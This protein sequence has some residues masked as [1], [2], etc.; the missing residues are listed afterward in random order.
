MAK[1]RIRAAIK[2]KIKARAQARSQKPPSRLGARRIKS[3]TV[4]ATSKVIGKIGTVKTAIENLDA[5]RKLQHFRVDEFAPKTRLNFTKGHFTVKTVENGEELEEALRLRFHVFHK[6]YMAKR[7]GT[8]VDVDALDL[9]CDH[10]LIRDNRTGKAV[11]TYRFNS[12]TFSDTF[13]SSSEFDIDDVLQLPGNKLELGRAAIH[14]DYRTGAVIAMIWRG[15]SEYMDL[16]DTDVMFGC[17]SIKTTDPL[18]IGLVTQYFQKKGLLSDALK[19]EP[20]KKYRVKSLRKALDY[21]EKHPY[22]YDEKAVEK[23]IPALVHAYIKMG[24]KTYGWPAIDREFK[25]IDFLIVLKVKELEGSY[26]RRYRDKEESP[27]PPD[28]RSREASE[29]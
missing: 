4:S 24:V 9:V 18:T 6:E 5:K 28:E 19:V 15:L 2:K 7:R 10:L 20:T 14:K 1:G 21:I 23:M 11:G 29:T 13:Y 12:S 25:C 27:K 22:E 26:R 16:V 17:A 8:G 3:A